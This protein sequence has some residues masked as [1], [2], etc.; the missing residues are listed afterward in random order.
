MKKYFYSHFISIEILETELD[1]L[2][3][4]KSE[5]EELLELAHKNIHNE[6][7]DTIL[8]QLDEEDK[9]KFLK[10]VEEDEHGKIWDH[11]KK[12]TKNIEAKIKQAADQIRQELVEDIKK[13]KSDR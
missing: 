10:L 6:V 4:N 12:K 13:L 7:M 5:K 9:K 8:S 1:S 3:L 2:S 11:L